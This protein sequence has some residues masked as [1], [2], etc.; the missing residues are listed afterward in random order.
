MT[1]GKDVEKA[2]SKEG[3]QKSYRTILAQEISSGQKELERPAWGLLISGLSAGLDVGW[4][5]FLMGVMLTL[6]RDSLPHPVVE[7]L[8]ANM[9]AVGFL[10]VVLGRSELFT[11]HTTLAVLPVLGGR[12]SVAQL[13]RLWALVYLSNLIG[14]SLFAAMTALVGPSLGVLSRPALG[15]IAHGVVAHGSWQMLASAILA[16][17]LMGLLSWLVTASRDTISQIF[18]VW[19]VTTAIGLSHLHHV[20]AGTAEVLAGLYAGQGIT[21]A[22]IGRFLLL[23]TLGNAL[24]GIF[25]VALLKFGH[26]T[27]AGED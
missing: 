6:V 9:Y 11:E 13:L 23:V 25:F 24:G 20:I 22:D 17:W 2:D 21:G 4:S 8:V 19:L 26:A 5:L 7:I 27:Q 1:L 15:E 3:S 18:F 16:G 12:A 14:V 10:F